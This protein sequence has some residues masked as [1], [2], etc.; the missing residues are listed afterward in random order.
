MAENPQGGLRVL[1]TSEEEEVQQLACDVF[2]IVYRGLYEEEIANKKHVETSQS[3]Q[4]ALCKGRKPGA[5]QKRKY[6]RKQPAKGKKAQIGNKMTKKPRMIFANDKNEE[7]LR[8]EY[9]DVQVD[10]T[11]KPHFEL[12]Q[13]WAE[14]SPFL[15]GHEH[16]IAP[17]EICFNHDVTGW[18]FECSLFFDGGDAD[19]EKPPAAPRYGYEHRDKLSADYVRILDN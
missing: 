12:D 4:P 2:E 1:N 9:Q 17:K 19:A 14:W 18:N 15:A 5:V 11:Y 8:Q 7:Q 6:K 13:S 10:D 16:Y 3:T